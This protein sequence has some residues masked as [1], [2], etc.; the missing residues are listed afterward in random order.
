MRALFTAATGMEA[1]QTRID[2]VANNLANVNTT[3]FKR[4]RAD[5]QDLFYETIR[6]PGAEAADGSVLPEGIQVGHGTRLSAMSR[7]QSQGDRVNTGRS[8]DLAIDG[9]GFFQLTRPDGEI[10]YTRDGTFRLNRDGT[11]VNVQGYEVTPAI[12]FP[13]DAVQITIM[14]DGTISVL[15]GQSNVAQDLGQIELVRFVN[16]AGLR[17]TGNNLAVA[18]EASGVPETGIADVDGFGAISQGF[19]ESSNVNIA[20][21]LVQMILAQ[22]SFEV[23]S[24]VIQAGDEMLQTAANLHR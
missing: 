14:P 7:I 4:S 16:P 5:F 3:G 15:T 20:E 13:P 24:R 6:A 2:A 21:E 22:R 18:T 1:Q 8:L 23:N 17:L 10:A 9:E 19:L 12:Q 11:L